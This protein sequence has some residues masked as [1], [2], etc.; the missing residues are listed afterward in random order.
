MITERLAGGILQVALDL[1]RRAFNPIFVHI[2]L[3]LLSTP[4]DARATTFPRN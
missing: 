4:T 3:L 1:L 2:D